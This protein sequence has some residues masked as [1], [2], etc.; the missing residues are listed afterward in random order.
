MRNRK[1]ILMVLLSVLSIGGS[2]GLVTYGN[3]IRQDI[4]QME[5]SLEDEIKQT[6]Q[7]KQSVVKID[8]SEYE[9]ILKDCNTLGNE[10]LERVK[11]YLSVSVEGIEIGSEEYKKRIETAREAVVAL[12][13]CFVEGVDVPSTWYVPKEYEDFQ[14]NWQMESNLVFDGEKIPVL[15]TCR[16]ADNRVLA[17]TYANYKVKD[18]KFGTPT[19]L[20][21]SHG[22]K[23]T[24]VTLENGIGAEEVY[25]QD[26]LEDIEQ[27]KNAI[28][29]AIENNRGEPQREMTEEEEQAFGDMNAARDQLMEEYNKEQKEGG[30]N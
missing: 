12:E 19:V 1:V 20:I 13:A 23:H 14:A 24:A 7:A 21:T 29:D 2:V 3:H 4:H 10:V 18:G 15:W 9:A 28:F 5:T 26:L 6:E 22:N 11:Q 8:T 27:S 16:D 17:F 25:G 30:N